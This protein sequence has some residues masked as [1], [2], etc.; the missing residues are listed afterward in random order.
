MRRLIIY[1]PVSSLVTLFA[2]ILQNPQDT[3]ARADVRLMSLVVQFLSM[4]SSDENTAVRRM[5]G[6]CAE[7]ERI[8]N[9]VIERAE[10]ETHSRRKRK[11]D[12]DSRGKTAPPAA[13]TPT[14]PRP[15]PVA[16]VTPSGVFSPGPNVD[17][18]FTPMVDGFGGNGEVTWMSDF[19]SAEGPSLMTPTSGMTPGFGETLAANLGDDN[20]TNLGVFQQIQQPFVPPDLWQMLEWDWGEMAGAGS[21]PVRP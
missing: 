16:A 20:A 3:R 2:N 13:V 14:A 1:F 10:K 4:L 17:L 18:N 11:N 6:I 21:D 7:F 8:A 9:V 19:S 15:A 5:L 12:D